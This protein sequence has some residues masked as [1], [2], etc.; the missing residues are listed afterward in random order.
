MIASYSALALALASFFVDADSGAPEDR[1]TQCAPTVENFELA[2]D[3]AHEQYLAQ[4]AAMSLLQVATEKGKRSSIVQHRGRDTVHVMYATTMN[5]TGPGDVGLMASIMSL[6]KN[7]V[8]PASAVI[9]MIV[10]K[11]DVLSAKSFVECF[12]GQWSPSEPHPALEVVEELPLPFDPGSNTHTKYLS[13]NTMTFARWLM[14]AYFPNVNKVFYIDTDTIIQA[15]IRQLYEADMDAALLLKTCGI[16]CTIPHTETLE[17]HYN[18]MKDIIPKNLREEL[19]MNAGVMLADLDRWREL[20]FTDALFKQAESILAANVSL[21]DQ[22]VLNMVAKSMGVVD[23]LPKRF[24]SEGAGYCPQNA[25]WNAL[26][27]GE[28]I[29]CCN[30]GPDGLD[31]PVEEAA[32]LH[33]SGPD[34]QWDLLA[35]RAPGNCAVLDQYLPSKMCKIS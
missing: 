28:E 22:L 7:L 29:D 3:V 9:H 18:T 30:P 21:D 5:S 24:N 35:G 14:P 13:A 1:H 23:E 20:N 16:L 19:V 17:K 6:S 34:K 27:K 31:L 2:D 15:D 12:E 11:E 33:W 26:L 32:V 25:R 8:E 10:P 4:V